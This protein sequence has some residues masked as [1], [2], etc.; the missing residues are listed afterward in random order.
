M[1]CNCS[2]PGLACRY[3]I[4]RILS[5]VVNLTS[6]LNGHRIFLDYYFCL[7]RCREAIPS[8]EAVGNDRSTIP[9][10]APPLSMSSRGLPCVWAQLPPGCADAEA[11]AVWGWVDTQLC[12]RCVPLVRGLFLW[13]QLLCRCNEATPSDHRWDSNVSWWPY[14]KCWNRIVQV[15][16][17]CW[18]GETGSDVDVTVLMHLVAWNC[19]SAVICMT[20]YTSCLCLNLPSTLYM[21]GKQSLKSCEGVS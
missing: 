15:L 8:F 14:D 11:M 20:L 5:L 17:Y 3:I 7:L 19:S 9:H 18:R 1:K 16:F 4:V 6:R 21:K 12:W 10:A 2:S 13:T